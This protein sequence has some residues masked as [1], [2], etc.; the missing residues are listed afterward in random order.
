MKADTSTIVRISLSVFL[1]GAAAFLFTLNREES[2]ERPEEFEPGFVLSVQQIDKEIDG[3]LEN[4]GVEKTWVKKKEIGGRNSQ[5]ARIE[6]RVLIP[7]TIIPVLVNHEFNMLARRYQGR[8]IATE[9]I[10]DNI[11]TIHILLHRT[12]IQTV[13]LKINPDMKVKGT[14]EQTKKI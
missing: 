10:R 1:A 14:R 8:A 13:I 9:N 12:I 6:R 3:I 2:A 7:P 5:F 11:V 4:F